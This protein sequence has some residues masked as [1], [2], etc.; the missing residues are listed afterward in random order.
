MEVQE[1]KKPSPTEELAAE[2]LGSA[3]RLE[4]LIL[5][6]GAAILILFG[7]ALA[8]V[9]AWWL[10]AHWQFTLKFLAAFIPLAVLVCWKN[11]NR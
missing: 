3:Q 5:M 1:M 10:V 2:L 11:P 9:F 7:L 8:Y 6:A 4:H